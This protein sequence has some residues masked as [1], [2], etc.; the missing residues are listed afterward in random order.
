M[1]KYETPYRA[2]PRQQTPRGAAP[3]FAS[4]FTAE[5]T[6][7]VAV[8]V[9]AAVPDQ[10]FAALLNQRPDPD[11]TGAVEVE[12]GWPRLPVRLVGRSSVHLAICHPLLFDIPA[13]DIDGLG[14]FDEPNA[15]AGRLWFFGG[16]RSSQTRHH[17]E[18]RFEFPAYGILVRRPPVT[19]MAQFGRDDG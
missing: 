9:G 4:P 18:N 16:L 7:S 11:G 17:P 3:H 19:S 10:L 15:G 2:L 5:L 13:Q 14:L 12:G 8:R 6:Y 1:S